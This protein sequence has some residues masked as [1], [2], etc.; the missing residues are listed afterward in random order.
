[1]KI[2]KIDVLLDL[3]KVHIDERK[4]VDGRIEALLVQGLLVSM[5]AEFENILKKLTN[6]RGKS[7]R[8]SGRCD[9]DVKYA[10]RAFRSASPENIE[11]AVG[12]FG[13]S[14]KHEFERL[15]NGGAAAWRAYENIIRN[16]NDVAH[17]RPFQMTLRE[18]REFYESGHVVLDWFESALWAGNK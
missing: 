15:K 16:R 2:D 11:R 13:D 7:L 8:E 12:R 10:D 5:C 18:V 1:M 6:A 17:G 3:C 4:I 9:Y 14:N